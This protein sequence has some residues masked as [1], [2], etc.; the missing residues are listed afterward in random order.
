MAAL[1]G[2]SPSDEAAIAATR[3]ILRACLVPLSDDVYRTLLASRETAQYFAGESGPSGGEAITARRAVFDEGLILFV[4]SP[5]HGEAAEAIA[6]IGHALV[7]PRL[8][9]LQTLPARFLVLTIGL[10]QEQLR[11]VLAREI[12]DPVLLDAS[13]NAWLKKLFLHLDL[14]LSVYA[15]TERNAHWY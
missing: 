1:L 15:A 10:V 9:T 14:L 11:L 7:R 6:A 12:P 2:Y 8:S 3:D 5:I 4:N 13:T